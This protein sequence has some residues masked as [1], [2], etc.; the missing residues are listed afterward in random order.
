MVTGWASGPVTELTV[1]ARTVVLGVVG[2]VDR[3]VDVGVGVAERDIALD[4][5]SA[6]TARAAG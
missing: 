2:R 6:K 3:L 5:T 1:R 4:P